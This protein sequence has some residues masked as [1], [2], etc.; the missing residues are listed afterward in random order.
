[1]GSP[2]DELL[3]SDDETQHLVRITR[4]FWMGKFPVTQAQWEGVVG[5]NPSRF[6]GADL[7]VEG[8]SWDDISESGG[9]LDKANRFGRAG[10]AFSLP[11]EAQ[12]EYACRA[13]TTT[14]L[15]NGMDL[16]T[17]YGNCP[18]LDQ[19]A[20]YGGNSG[21][22]THPVGQKK[23]KAWG[24]HDMHG[25]VWEWCSDGYD[26]YPPG[27][28]VDPRGADSGTYRVLRGGSWCLG[29]NCCRAASRTYYNP[30]YGSYGVG[31]RLARSSVP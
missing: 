26:D 4:G 23:A 3:R 11:T 19:V 13:G 15:N 7:P 25:N 5:S 6:D 18:N 12:W 31:F 27:P 2:E 21:E 30:A 14:A 16:T 17:D 22:T 9:F 10:E 20:W 28:L 1:M 8:V 29:A 24:L